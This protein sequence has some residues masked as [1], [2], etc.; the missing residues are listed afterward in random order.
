MAG[1]TP[2][3]KA[4]DLLA[5]KS[6][7]SWGAISAGAMVSLA[8]YFLL[9]LLGIAAGLEV[10]RRRPQEVADSLGL[11]IAIFSIFTLLVSMFFG[12]W[13]TSRLAVGESK[14]EAVLYGVILWGVLFVGMF[15]LVG[16]GVRVGF[17][18]M[19]GLASG[20]VVV[21]DDDPSAASSQ[22]VATTLI[23]R[24]NSQY[25]GDKFVSDLTKMGV[26]EAKARQIEK[27]T[28]EHIDALKN[29]P[30][31][32]PGKIGEAA[33]DPAVREYGAQAAD[34]SRKAAWYTLLGVVVSMAA[35]IVGS[36]IG[37]GDLPVPVP[38]LG[39]RR[40]PVDPR[41]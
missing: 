4:T 10:A 6:R 7:V 11:G 34:V 21:A 2:T 12:G 37:S 9:T 30:A 28:R 35:V 38:I 3:L 31:S 15:W 17:G 40:T 25:G 24:Y 29:D 23:D 18:A 1:T 16:A 32:L 22:G 26:D 39:V 19:L 41:M 8:I 36:L 33:K 14:L 5:V 13:A 20:A 27:T